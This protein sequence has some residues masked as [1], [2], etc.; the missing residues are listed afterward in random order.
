MP[1]G[2]VFR[3]TFIVGS[4]KPKPTVPL[5]HAPMCLAVVLEKVL[6]RSV[7]LSEELQLHETLVLRGMNSEAAT[8]VIAAAM[9]A[10]ET[11]RPGDVEMVRK[12]GA[13]FGDIGKV[14]FTRVPRGGDGGDTVLV[15]SAID[16]V[17][18]AKGCEYKTARRMVWRLFKEYYGIDL[19]LDVSSPA[20]FNS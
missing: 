10:T 13:I 5:S 20:K 16:L 1:N 11:E 18:A 4:V 9:A 12:V 3:D 2:V 17:M 7:L 19:N 14:R 15:F 8:A 6:A